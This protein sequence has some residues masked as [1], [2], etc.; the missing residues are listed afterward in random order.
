VRSPPL[1][2]CLA[3][4]GPYFAIQAHEPGSPRPRPWLPLAGLL[5]EPAAL[6][7]RIA[8][9][10]DG[11]AAAGGRPASE[12][13]FRVAASVAQLGVTARLLAPVLGAE[14]LGGA[15]RIDPEQTWW[16]PELGG[17][18][19]LSVPAQ[20]LA[21]AG[22]AAGQRAGPAGCRE[23]LTGPVS[24]LVHAVAAR[25]VSPLTLWGNV[26]SAISGAAA[27]IAVARPDL[28]RQARA[29]AAAALEFP[30]LA[31]AGDGPPGTAGFRRRSCCL[32]YRLSP[33]PGAALC[34]DCVLGTR[35]G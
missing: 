30:A 19:R 10:R 13:E 21:A 25:S 35:P 17:P 15:L 8:R 33:G 24:D 9:V 16:V 1:A 26:A 27:M 11:L 6:T 31:G 29:A 3:E 22:P 28:A 2:G 4:L 12:V 32:I 20:A 7:A 34:G 14:V 5:R 18:F 23:V